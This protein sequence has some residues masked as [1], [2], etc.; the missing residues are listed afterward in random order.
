MFVPQNFQ[1]MDWTSSS[2]LADLP[3]LSPRPTPCLGP[4]KDETIFDA[5]RTTHDAPA[6]SVRVLS[7]LSSIYVLASFRP[8][9]STAP[10]QPKPQKGMVGASSDVLFLCT[11][12]SR[13]R[14]WTELLEGTSVN[15]AFLL[16]LCTQM[17]RTHHMCHSHSC[18]LHSVC[19]FSSLGL[20]TMNLGPI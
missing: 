11:A 20:H 17:R 3:H 9:N 18:F 7:A 4:P 1:Q 15:N 13:G 19:W 14:S 6:R 8:V 2:D 12:G 16:G 10:S 5:R